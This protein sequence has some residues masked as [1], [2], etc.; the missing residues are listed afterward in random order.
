MN[1]TGEGVTVKGVTR[2]RVRTMGGAYLQVYPQGL[3]GK[4]TLFSLTLSSR[5]LFILLIAY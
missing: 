2:Y 1:I 3:Q 4:V 5:V